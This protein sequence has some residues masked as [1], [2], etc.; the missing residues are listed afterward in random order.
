METIKFKITG[1]EPLLQNNPQTV[2]P[3]NFYAKAKKRLTGKKK[4]TEEDLLEIRRL[5]V[6]SKCYFDENIG[7]YVPSTWISAGIAGASFSRAKVSKAAIRSCVFP[8]EP[9]IKL[10]FAD[11][12]LVKTL[13][14]IPGN[15]KFV[16]TLLLKQQQVRIAKC[17]PIFHGWNFTTSLEFDP[18][19]IDRADLIGILSFVATYVG[20]GDFRP[21]YGRARFTEL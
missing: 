9:K 14:D 2:D 16:H 20:F 12:K 6:L 19:I 21:T 3:F 17:A 13:D 5:E 18:E 1:I 15:P 7:I 8:T 4:K 10:H 11:E